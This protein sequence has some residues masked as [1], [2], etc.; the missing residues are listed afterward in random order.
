M[1]SFISYH[2]TFLI[3]LVFENSFG[4]NDVRLRLGTPTFGLSKALTRSQASKACSS[5]EAS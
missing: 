4:S 5:A 3:E 2:F 1:S